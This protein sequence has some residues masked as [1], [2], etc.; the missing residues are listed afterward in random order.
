LKPLDLKLLYQLINYISPYKLI[1]STTIFISICFGVLSTLRPLLIQYA[2][3]NYIMH[4]DSLGLLTIMLIVLFLL[5]LEAF[6][7]YQFIYKSNYLSQKIIQDLRLEVFSKLLKF[8]INYFDKTPTGQL[9]TRVI[10]DMES[11]ASIFSQGLLVVFGDLFK[12][13]LIIICMFLVSWEL[14]LISLVFLPLLIFL[15]I[16]FQN[17]MHS[18]FQ[19]IRKYVAK[20]NIFLF[21]HIIGMSIIQLFGKEDEELGKFKLI[22]ALHR[23]AHIKTVLYFSIFLPIV[24]VFSAIVMGLVVWYGSVSMIDN[25]NITIGQIVA[26][27]LFINMLF[28]PLRAIADR[29][30]VLQMGLV[31]SS[32][33][34]HI[35]NQPV[36]E[37]IDEIVEKSSENLLGKILFKNVSFSYNLN[38]TVLQNV[39]FDVPVN[40]TVAIIGP[41]GS[42]K[43]TIIN[44]LMRWYRVNQGSI[45]IDGSNITQISLSVLRRNI[46]VVLQDTFFLSDSLLNN[47]KFFNDISNEDV[48]QAVRD[49][50]LEDFINQFPEKYNYQIGERGMG[51]SEGEKQ[52]ISFLRTYLLNPP[53]LILD[54]ATSSLDPL[55]EGLIQ[56]AIQNIT[57]N[58]TAIIIAHRISTIQ[59]ADKIIVL[60]NGKVIEQGTHEKLLSLK[61]KYTDFYKKQFT[62]L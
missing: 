50:G 8:R 47:I 29:F 43:T 7:Q 18:A 60:E 30:N 31:A 13:V 9:I 44:L 56:K 34:F 59:H 36:D 33:V 35:L 25:N 12:M 15:T 49:V 19:D 26:F 53:Y 32:R 46:G 37:E 28:R 27:I 48:Y 1:F 23:D 4:K 58:R 11:I 54:E 3:D 21:E 38:E 61:G 5:F 40:N 41:T 2:F 22:N 52:L 24:D 20:I 17:Y 42:G 51:L 55:T 14:A 57:K 6:L 16:I 39:T 10:S 62:Q 45:L